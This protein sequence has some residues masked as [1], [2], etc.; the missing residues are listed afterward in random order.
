MIEVH[1]NQKRAQDYYAKGY[2]TAQTLLDHWNDAVDTFPNKDY[3][4]DEMGN[5]LSYR[6][7]DSQASAIASWLHES[8]VKEGDVVSFQIPVWKEFAVMYVACLKIGA[9]I[10]PLSIAFNDADLSYIMNEVGSSAFVSVA[11][12][13]GKD[14]VNQAK[15]VGESVPALKARCIIEREASAPSE[16]AWESL[17]DCKD[18]RS[19]LPSTLSQTTSDS[20]A[21]ILSTSGTTGKPK[22]VLL[23]HNNLIFSERT[24]TRDLGLG[25]DDVMFMP[26]PLNHAT[27]F[28]HGLIA[29]ML[30]KGSCVIEEK[31][32]PK[33]SIELINSNNVTWSMGATPFIYDIL[34]HAENHSAS[35]S[36]LRFYLCG[37]A[38]VPDALIARAAKHG[39]KVCEV[40]GSTESCPH[41]F[42]PPAK[43]LLWNGRFS[44]IPCTGIEVKVVDKNREEVPDGVQGE[45]A[46]RGPHL[47]VGYLNNPEATDA[48][49]DAEGW[50][51]SG[52]LCTKD[53]EGR[54][55]INGRMKEIIIR[56]GINISAIEVDNN[57]DGCPLIKDHAC[58]G[59]KDDRLGE[60]IG[61]F[62]VSADEKNPPTLTDILSYLSEHNVAK[63]IWPEK[64]KVIDKIPRT[65]SGKVK[66]N[67]L[68]DL[69]ETI[70]S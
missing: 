18:G 3:I 2:W 33:E 48:V 37:G 65:E 23:T 20:I 66:R 30:L 50:F 47:F 42:V 44:G 63:R 38:P 5:R 15:R 67:H 6:E 45:E 24:F 32:S 22:A 35:L 14:L 53:A 61:L 16:T 17:L 60:R 7:C 69:F 36:S 12:F 52:D 62:I 41:I 55:K 4:I 21:L 11:S 40:Y 58:V 13:R 49:L 64:I 8:G 59:Y 1:L 43:T 51:Y 34:N 19:T 57:V 26:A 70:E 54:I 68:A 31:F 56:G 28:N 9:V 46:S 39:I 25:A 29:P 27:G 10:H